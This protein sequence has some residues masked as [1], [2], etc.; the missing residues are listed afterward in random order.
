MF[1]VSVSLLLPTEVLLF[2]ISV[3]R[4]SV[5]SVFSVMGFLIKNVYKRGRL[6]LNLSFSVPLRV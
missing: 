3:F 1:S 6:D 4:S 2:L 5:F